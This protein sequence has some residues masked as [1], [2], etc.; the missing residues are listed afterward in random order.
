VP[1]FNYRFIGAAGK[2]GADSGYVPLSVGFA[3]SGRYPVQTNTGR[4][5]I[6]RTR[7][8]KRKFTPEKNRAA[9]RFDPRAWCQLWQRSGRE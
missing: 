2:E 9:V 4:R 3:D 8:L 1:N 7:V 5:G 6:L